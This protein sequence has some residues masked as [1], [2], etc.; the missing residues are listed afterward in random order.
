MTLEK[1]YFSNW[2]NKDSHFK[3]RKEKCKH[4]FFSLATW[5]SSLPSSMPWIWFIHSPDLPSGRNACS[6]IKIHFPGTSHGT[7]SKITFLPQPCKGS[8][9]P[10]P[11]LYMQTVSGGLYAQYQYLSLKDSNWY[12][13]GWSDD[14]GGG[15]PHP[16][17]GL[18]FNTHNPA[19]VTV[20]I[21]CI[22]PIL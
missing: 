12:R 15:G 6:T 22:L 21:T 9:D 20:Y 1:Q 16:M 19:N 18:S 5:A 4:K 8:A 14:C 10:R 11:A 7:S 2:G 17:V 13:I 3:T